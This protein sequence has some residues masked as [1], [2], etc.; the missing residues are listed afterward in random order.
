MPRGFSDSICGLSSLTCKHMNKIFRLRSWLQALYIARSVGA[1]SSDNEFSLDLQK[2][3]SP[4]MTRM[5]DKILDS[6]S[7]ATYTKF[8]IVRRHRVCRFAYHSD[9]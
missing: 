6:C 3:V 1:C 2:A 4:R 8:D 9:L 7:H 5:Q